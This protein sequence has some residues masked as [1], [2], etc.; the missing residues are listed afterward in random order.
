[1]CKTAWYTRCN[2]HCLH[3]SLVADKVVFNSQY[4]MNSFLGSIDSHLKLI[5]DHRPRGLA[6]TIR[7]KCTVLYFPLKV[8]R[9]KLT[10]CYNSSLSTLGQENTE[11]DTLCGS[12]DSRLL[13]SETSHEDCGKLSRSDSTH[14]YPK[15]DPYTHSCT[16]QSKAPRADA[17][18]EATMVGATV[19]PLHIVWP[20]RWWVLNSGS[21]SSVPSIPL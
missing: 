20:H 4:N 13:T 17:D 19:S 9:T 10:G 6:E 1:M 15:D 12:V 7:P 3:C 8:E 5:P 14:V 21:C 11:S 2:G 16:S 18:D